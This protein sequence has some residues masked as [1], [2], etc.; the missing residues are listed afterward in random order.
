M[1]PFI[2]YGGTFDPVHE[3]HLAIGRAIADA[4][5]TPVHFLPAADPPHRLPP[6]ASAEQRAT[7]LELATAGDPRLIVDRRELFRSGPSFT[8][9]TLQQVRGELG[10]SASIIWALGLD[11]LVQLDTWHDWRR[12]FSLAHLLG[13]QRPGTAVGKSWLRQRAATVYPELAPR[14]R[15]F[16]QLPGHPHGF[17]ASLP[18][19]PLRAESA[20]D[21]RRRIA[22]GEPWADCVP[23][24]VADYI[25][26]AGLYR[27]GT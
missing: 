19:H 8:V 13:V 27:R 23:K 2:L 17:Y 1:T 24:A 9:D 26:T 10:Q 22:A 25:G 3:G 7:M 20:T 4:F 18:M 21:V 14:W 5:D 16:D 12:I 15:R 6:G 11:S